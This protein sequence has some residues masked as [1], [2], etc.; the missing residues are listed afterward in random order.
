[1]AANS[2]FNGSPKHLCVMKLKG[3][4]QQGTFLIGFLILALP[5]NGAAQCT[6]CHGDVCAKWGASVHANTQTDVAT[7]LGQSHAGE[8]PAAV[9]TGEN[10]I[11]CHAPTSVLAKGGMTEGQALG[12]FFSTSNG[13]FTANTTTANS[14]LWPHLECGACHNVP[15]D[16]P[17]TMPELALFSSQMRQYVPMAD[18]SALCGQ[19]HGNLQF[20]N[21]DHL[22]FNAWTNSRHARTQT[23]V[24]TELSQ[25][26]PGETPAAVT[27][28]ED[29]VA[30][31]APT[32]V[33]AG[34]GMTASQALGYFFTTTNGQ[35]SAD[36]AS[37]HLSEWPGVS[38]T[39]CHDPHDPKKPSYFN[40]ATGQYQVLTNSALLC[41]Q[42]HGNLRFP[43]TDHLSY[44]IETGTGGIGVTNQQTMPGATCTDCHMYTSTQDG[45]L[46]M[47]YH[48]HSW[49]ITIQEAGGQVISSCTACHP[50]MDAQ[51]AHTAITNWQSEFQTLDATVQAN[52]ARAAALL[53]GSQDTNRLAALAES[54]HNLS[55]AESDESGGFH[56][57]NY[58]MALLKDANSR[59]LS[60]PVLTAE[61]QGT[62]LVVSWTGTGTLQSAGSLTGL[63]Q[64]V[65][66]AAN[67]LV[68]PVSQAEQRFYRLRP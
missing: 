21:T 18:A 31:H 32:A 53:Q 40:S 64:D 63:W 65:Q 3:R 46:S 60:L 26:H 22:I 9:I 24:A 43:D 44:N 42:C 13:L 37:A 47:S 38:C 29:C 34:G 20:S 12:Y 16:H 15:G 10:C 17:D 14:A 23:D 2:K 7:E 68:I 39:A 4:F 59:V 30:C 5:K 27:A 1:M 49:A 52:V 28:G 41:G 67:P 56:N 50:T 6:D 11:A 36:T 45:T 25:S 48:G 62:N 8:T 33:L 35:F 66:G 19:C 51:A 57:H 61:L 54:Q 55:Y 58:L